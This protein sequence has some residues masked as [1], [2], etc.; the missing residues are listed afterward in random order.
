MGL[1]ITVGPQSFE[2]YFQ[3]GA[4][5]GTLSKS[6]VPRYQICKNCSRAFEGLTYLADKIQK[7]L[8]LVIFFIHIIQLF[9]SADWNCT[10]N[11]IFEKSMIVKEYEAIFMKT[12]YLLHRKSLNLMIGTGTW[13]FCFKHYINIITCFYHHNKYTCVKITK[14]KML[15]FAS[16]PPLSG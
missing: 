9:Q 14:P 2:D 6:W 5:R 11:C 4:K 12:H 3:K 8:C 1:S 16:P 10:D 15:F 7:K 13:F